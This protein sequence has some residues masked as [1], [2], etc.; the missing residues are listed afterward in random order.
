M[1]F[2]TASEVASYSGLASTS[3]TLQQIDTAEALVA[4][5]LGCETLEETA[6]T[7]TIYKGCISPRLI[8]EH[9]PV[10]SISSVTSVSISDTDVTM[11]NLYLKGYWTLFYPSSA[12]GDGVKIV[13][14]YNSGWDADDSVG[15]P[16]NISKA[17]MITTAALSQNPTAQ[18]KSESIGDYSYTMADGQAVD[19]SGV[20]DSAKV[21]LA[22]YRRPDYLF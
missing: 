11:S 2:I 14:V 6:H 19:R 9:G 7:D 4:S 16:T 10:A 3:I 8:L 1:S 15:L 20:P 21:L 12:F 22:P 17:I 5:Y 18:F 13:V